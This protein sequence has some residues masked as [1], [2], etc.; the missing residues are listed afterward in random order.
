[1]WEVHAPKTGLSR[2]QERLADGVV[3]GPHEIIVD[4]DVLKLHGVPVRP[5]DV[6]VAPCGDHQVRV[7]GA[8]G[9]IQR[10]HKGTFLVR[11]ELHHVSSYCGITAA[12]K[13][14]L[15]LSVI[16]FLGS[17]FSSYL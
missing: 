1:M 10:V 9:L 2:P 13:R 11:A 8:L 15:K 3:M 16:N 7:H 5:E 17:V 4:G 6:S 12:K 14:G